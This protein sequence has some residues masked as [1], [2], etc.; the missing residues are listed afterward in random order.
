MSNYDPPHS[1]L[2]AFKK[3]EPL[4]SGGSSYKGKSAGQR[5][6]ATMDRLKK[7]PD[8]TLQKEYLTLILIVFDK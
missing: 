7:T 5:H 6:H 3:N 4:T 8:Q 1:V 2:Y